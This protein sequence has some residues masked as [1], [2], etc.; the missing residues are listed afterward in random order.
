M[1][2]K[3]NFWTDNF[4]LITCIISFLLSV[5]YFMKGYREGITPFCYIVIGM[6]LLYIPFALIFKR[7]AF[8]Y[9]YLIYATVL[10]FVL[11]FTKTCLYNNYTALF[12]MF[13]VIMINPKLKRPAYIIYLLGICVAFLFN[14]ENILHF[15]IHV[16]RSCWFVF[17]MNYVV[18]NKYDRKKL[19]IYEDEMK[20]LDQL[21]NGKIYQ[22]EVEGFSENTVYRK[23]KAA[24][25]RNG[26]LTKDELVE[27]YR[28]S[29]EKQ[30]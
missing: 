20:I 13:I 8:S 3:K 28:I 19:I 22:K 29:K 30:N 17:I 27:A 9:F 15:L 12:V 14:D 11:A 25:E 23:L 21:C 10:I 16:L 2:E 6:N 24:R 5:L 18:E 1:N 7:K 4:V 26:N